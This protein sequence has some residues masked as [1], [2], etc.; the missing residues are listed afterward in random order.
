MSFGSNRIIAGIFVLSTLFLQGCSSTAQYDFK[1]HGPID[2]VSI[3]GLSEKEITF[4]ANIEWTSN[5][6]SSAG[7]NDHLARNIAKSLRN[8]MEPL[9]PALQS[10][11]SSE[12]KA[13][14]IEVDVVPVQRSTFGLAEYAYA[15]FYQH[16]LLEN[17]VNI[18]FRQEQDGIMPTITIL[19]DI[20]SR[21]NPDRFE[22]SIR[23]RRAASFGDVLLYIEKI[24]TDYV[25]Y[26]NIRYPNVQYILD[27]PDQVAS[28]L[29]S[30]VPPLGKAI[31]KNLYQ[32]AK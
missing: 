15:S 30:M 11:I 25:G 16:H 17:F 2:K 6:Y 1:K 26:S 20:R 8:K 29:M 28:D 9:H 13:H 31:A 5:A 22:R 27:H 21:T 32:S 10:A 12:L 23:I 18:G 24:D 4:V 3:V 7:A 14:G 19:Y